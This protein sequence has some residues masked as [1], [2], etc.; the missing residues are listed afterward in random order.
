MSLLAL[1]FLLRFLRKFQFK[2]LIRINNGM[3][4]PCAPPSCHR[5]PLDPPVSVRLYYNCL[6]YI[7]QQSFILKVLSN[8]MYHRLYGLLVSYYQ[9]S[10]PTVIYCYRFSMLYQMLSLSYLI[11]YCTAFSCL[12]QLLSLGLSIVYSTA[13]HVFIKCYHWIYPL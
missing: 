1:Y 11:V 13:F 5:R 4:S 6:C 9:L 8:V 7:A 2:H 12:Y 10:C 3:R